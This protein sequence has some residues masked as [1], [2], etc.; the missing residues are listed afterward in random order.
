MHISS[1]MLDYKYSKLYDIIA[2]SWMLDYYH[3]NFSKNI[4]LITFIMYVLVLHVLL[5]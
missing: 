4:I 5:I 1:Y 2:L 3:Y